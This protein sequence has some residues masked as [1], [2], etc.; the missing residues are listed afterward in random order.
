MNESNIP[1][2]WSEQDQD[3]AWLAQLAQREKELER[4]YAEESSETPP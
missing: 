3:E 4:F 2:W 1:E